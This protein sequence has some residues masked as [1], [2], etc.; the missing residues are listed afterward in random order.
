MPLREI[1]LLTV[2]LAIRPSGHSV[3]ILAGLRAGASAER[4][5]FKFALA[6]SSAVVAAKDAAGE[7]ASVSTNLTK[8]K[9]IHPKF[10][11]GTASIID[12]VYVTNMSYK[13]FSVSIIV[14]VVLP[15]RV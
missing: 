10:I 6:T 1:V 2:A 9:R 12:G 3:T 15:K 7:H 13:A 5:T 4:Q 11:G 14:S 8:A